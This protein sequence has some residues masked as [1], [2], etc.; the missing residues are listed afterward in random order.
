MHS[1]RVARL[2]NIDVR[3]DISWLF[4]FVLMTW[5]LFATFSRWHTTWSREL[6]MGVAVAGS[7]AFFGC[8][9][10]HEL[11]HCLVARRFGLRVGSVTLFLF[12]GVS[13]IEQQP[14]SAGVEFLT[15]VAG[16]LTSLI[17]GTGLLV[18]AGLFLGV[19]QTD[20]EGAW[21]SLPH[22]GAV[23]T[24][25]V[26]L[27]SIN[28][29]IGLFNLIPGFPL[30]GGR[31]LRA[32]LWRVTGDLS[33]A[34][35]WSS[36]LGQ[37]IGWAFIGTG[38]AMTFG[39]QVPFFGTGLVSGLWLALI[40]W[41]LH[42][43]ASRAH[44]RMAIDEAFVGH[45]V[46]EL[47]RTNGKTVAPSLSLMALV[48][49]VFVHSDERAVPVVLDDKLVG[50]V[51]VSDVRTMSATAWSTTP[52]S[53]VMRVAPALSVTS[54]E[55]SL[56]TAFEQLARRDIGQLPVVASGGRLVGLLLRRDVARWLELAWRPQ[57][58][59]RKPDGPNAPQPTSDDVARGGGVDGVAHGPGP[60]ESHAT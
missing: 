12:G 26:W 43:A 32:I 2:F 50:L 27:G 36:S 56:A 54:P 5:N 34:T 55:Q 31:M 57:T 33:A 53:S 16:P 37:L 17:L 1:Y 49:D 10:L 6:Q 19:G 48:H 46:A 44:M 42:S 14:R 18:V 35:R 21:S 24:F 15:A 25:A 11:A 59:E 4:I 20:M 7:L 52:V 41:F 60:V 30:D 22:L 28:I 45:T 23:A 51:A 47:M 58:D 8:I 40:G 3:V 29:I 9:L 38:L 39:A 13:K